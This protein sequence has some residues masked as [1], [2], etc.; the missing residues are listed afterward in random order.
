[1]FRYFLIIFSVFNETFKFIVS[2]MKWFHFMYGSVKSEIT[3][4]KY[5]LTISSVIFENGLFDYW[6]KK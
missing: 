3:Q 2:C 4:L 6:S 5:H 1:M